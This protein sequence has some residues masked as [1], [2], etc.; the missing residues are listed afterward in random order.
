MTC[1]P[2]TLS[3]AAQ[4]PEGP[5]TYRF[6]T[7]DGVHA[8]NEFRDAELLLLETLWDRSPEDLLVV[9][10]NYGV[11]GTVLAAMSDVTMI[12]TSARAARLSRANVDQ[13]GATAII[14][15]VASPGELDSTFGTAC[16]APKPYTP[17]EVG[18]QRLADTFSVV[19]PGGR[20]YVAG[21][22]STGINRYECCL[23]KH[24]AHVETIRQRGSYRVLEVI[25][26]DK[27]D[28]QRY[29]SMDTVTASVGGTDL[30]MKTRP[31]LFSP[32]CLDDGTRLLAETVTVGDDETILDLC[33][34]YGPLGTYAAA[35]ADVNVIL[36]DDDIW[37][38]T[39][40]EATLEA[41]GVDGEVVTADCL[42]GV[43]CQVDRVL[44]NPPT[45]AGSG[46]L[47]EL[48]ADV[49]SVLDSNGELSVVHHRTLDL[50][51]YLTKVGEIAE[52]RTRNEHTVVTV[53]P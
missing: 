17:V 49:S 40:A 1:S 43:D 12:E 53:R 15:L 41:T 36:T 29:V 11:V 45:H 20:L 30:T 27:F 6:D 31:G 4:I 46:V 42:S 38:T 13:N 2:R 51:G 34:G 18:K 26:P 19:R 48:F 28:G 25:R 32:G 3:L 14:S 33:C 5:D 44:C 50:D 35:S 23:R 16:Y 47:S 52:T 37:A 21:Q 9:Q 7:V 39:C 8:K 24:A 10:A 22:P